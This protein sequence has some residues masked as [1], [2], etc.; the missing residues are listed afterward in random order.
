MPRLGLELLLPGMFFD[1]G[2]RV[3][4]HVRDLI[5][6]RVSLVAALALGASTI[7]HALHVEGVGEFQ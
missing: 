6:A 3:A 5:Q 1:C 4:C 2:L 7:T